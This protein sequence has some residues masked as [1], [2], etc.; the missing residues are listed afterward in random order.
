MSLS[1]N[2]QAVYN[3]GLVLNIISSLTSI[4]M[5]S[6]TIYFVSSK[7]NIR[8]TSVMPILRCL[9]VYSFFIGLVVQ[10]MFAVNIYP[11]SKV[12]IR[13]WP[14]PQPY[15]KI[16]SFVIMCGTLGVLSSLSL[17][18]YYCMKAVT[19][20][21]EFRSV[22]TAA[23][24][25]K[26]VIYLC[27]SHVLVILIT[28][29]VLTERFVQ[30]IMYIYAGLL[31]TFI[32]VAQ[33]YTAFSLQKHNSVISHGNSESDANSLRAK[34]MSRMAIML[35]VSLAICCLPSLVCGAIAVA[36]QS[37]KARDKSDENPFFVTVKYNVEIFIFVFS[38]IYPFILLYTNRPI[39]QHLSTA[40][41]SLRSHLVFNSASTDTNNSENPEA[42]NTNHGDTNST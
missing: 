12:F 15:S 42:S 13:L 8:S 38:A 11:S 22:F 4:V 27:V 35:F 26:H 19:S 14:C 2:E 18:T 9:C 10:P 34:K 28:V 5:N 1:R 20:W 33:L 41:R 3:S 21:T 16:Y 30:T 25:R 23:K 31:A 17:L 7:E 24:A 6:L 29:S 36:D 40:I 37:G 32:V 39:A